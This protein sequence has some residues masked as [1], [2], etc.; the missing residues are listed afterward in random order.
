MDI[1]DIQSRIT[2]IEERISEISQL[3]SGGTSNQG[4]FTASLA[5]AQAAQSPGGIGLTAPDGQTVR[6]LS[7]TDLNI[8]QAAISNPAS[9][10]PI[11]D[12]AA[13]KYDVDPSLV[14]AVIKT[15]SDFDPFA[16]SHSGAL[17]LMQLMPSNIQDSKV[18]DPFNPEQNINAGVSQLSGYLKRYNGNVDQALAAYNAGPGAVEE[19]HGIPPYNETENY[20]KK[21][22][23]LLDK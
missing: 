16:E 3:T 21:I 9:L 14:R 6:P 19:Y 12:N 23:S 13:E 20:I 18:S 7:P 1:S 15:E 8:Q 11:V 4:N 5:T 10:N 22:H 2:A 17:G